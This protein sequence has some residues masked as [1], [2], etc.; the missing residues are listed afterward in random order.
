LPCGLFV[1]RDA[2]V[3]PSSPRRH[4]R[5][6]HK[7]AQEHDAS[8]HRRA[9]HDGR[10]LQPPGP[11]GREVRRRGRVE[12][13]R[14]RGNAAPGWQR[15]A[16]QAVGIGQERRRVEPGGERGRDLAGEAVRGNVEQAERALDE[17]RNLPGQHVAVEQ[18]VREAGHGGEGVRDL[19]GQ[20]VA[21]EDEDR[22]AVQEA[23]AAG[24]AALQAVVGEVEVLQVG[25]ESVG[26]GAG[27]R[28]GP[29]AED[30]QLRQRGQERR[31]QGPG[32]VQA[33]EDELGHAAAAVALPHAGPGGAQG[34]RGV[35]PP[36][37]PV[38]AVQGGLEE[39]EGLGVIART[40]SGGGEVEQQQQEE[41]EEARSRHVAARLQLAMVHPL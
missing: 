8:C 24:D 26:D 14:A 38:E 37:E 32:E 28:V 25:R 39:Q 7:D 11:S 40:S 30:A 5:C 31:G 16:A 12:R 2:L 35:G 27:E 23:E 1:P 21:G 18:Q 34:R 33:L 20:A 29:E 22:G 10:V 6:R 4:R 19:A 15:R 17:R 9:R 41:E 13:R 3:P 36:G